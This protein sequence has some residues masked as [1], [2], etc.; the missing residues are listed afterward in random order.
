MP[1]I[2]ALS[3]Y[4]LAIVALA[5]FALEFI[6]TGVKDRINKAINIALRH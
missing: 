1:D 2:I 3:C 6:F 4:A 5:Y